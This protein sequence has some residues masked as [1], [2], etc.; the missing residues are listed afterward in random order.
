MHN[1]CKKYQP[2]IFRRSDIKKKMRKHPNMNVELRM[3]NFELVARRAMKNYSIKNYLASYSMFLLVSPSLLGRDG[4]G[5]I[6]FLLQWQHMLQ[7]Q[8]RHCGGFPN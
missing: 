5:F 8:P 2:I 4:R 1:M 6:K 7:H 3:W